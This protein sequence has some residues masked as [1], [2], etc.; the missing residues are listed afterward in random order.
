MLIS[1]ACCAQ[2]SSHIK[3]NKPCED[4]SGCFENKTYQ[5]SIAIVA[6]GH[7][8]DKYFRSR[9]GSQL[10]VE[11]AYEVIDR[12]IE[13]TG[14]TNKGFFNE[15][16]KKAQEK[17]AENLQRL[18]RDLVSLWREKV[19]QHIKDNPWNESENAFCSKNKITIAE[20]DKYQL[21][22]IYGTTL[23]AA[24]VTETFWFVLQI[25][26]GA[27]VVIHETGKPEI[28]VSDDEE[29]GFGITKSL[30]NKDVLENFR[31]NFGFERILGLTVAT[32]GVADSFPLEKYFEFTVSELLKKF[33]D[34]HEKT[35]KEL[36]SSLSQLSE[37]G[38]GDDV[39]IA[40]IFN[41][42]AAKA[43]IPIIIPAVQ[44]E[45]AYRQAEKEAKR[46]KY[47]L[48][49]LKQD[50]AD[51]RQKY[52]AREKA[53][54]AEQSKR[55]EMEQTIK[56]KETELQDKQAE[57]ERLGK[58]YRQA[59]EE[60]RS[61]QA[62]KEKA[63]KAADTEQREKIKAQRETSN[64]RRDRE[65]ERTKRGKAE[66]DLKD[67]QM[68]RKQVEQEV[69][70]LQKQLEK[71]K[72]QPAVSE[73][74]GDFVP[75]VPPA[76]SD[77]IAASYIKDG[78]EKMEQKDYEGALQIYQDAF[79]S[80]S[81]IKSD[82]ASIFN[83]YIHLAKGCIQ[84]TDQLFDEAKTS[85]EEARKCFAQSTDRRKATVGIAR[86][87]FYEKELNPTKTTGTADDASLNHRA[88]QGKSN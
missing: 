74:L 9:F 76:G 17:M 16:A 42:E 53:L 38:S 71:M 43:L 6:D 5:T 10:A 12:F 13:Q 73:P 52:D 3:N 69:K 15:D 68:R 14:K 51:W 2:G 22:S 47:E 19:L 72:K 77:R 55:R 32:D 70:D 57:I 21:V 83:G 34:D 75:Y 64:V 39:S 41:P 62:E 59:Q 27:C 25:G 80:F 88:A 54:A 7:G 35:K 87:S 49:I 46:A 30:C 67:E 82:Y 61:A 4:Y 85:F 36:E 11:A 18:E 60:L 8:G 81:T 29:Q 84:M 20:N 26:D 56:Q 24:A 23:L 48:D 65:A 50:A 78:K 86:I 79:K 63:S 31:H 28:A 40:G 33:V 37:Q 45:L 44:T 58:Q 66:Q 1:F